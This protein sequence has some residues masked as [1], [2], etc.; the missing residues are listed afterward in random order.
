MCAQAPPGTLPWPWGSYA[1]TIYTH[2]WMSLSLGLTCEACSESATVCSR[3]GR[4]TVYGAQGSV[5]GLAVDECPMWYEMEQDFTA[6]IARWVVTGN[7]TSV[8]CEAALS[9]FFCGQQRVFADETKTSISACSSHGRPFM[10][11]VHQCLSFCPAILDSC[12]QAEAAAW[13]E[14]KCRA[15]FIPSY[16]DILDLSGVSP[17]L[18]PPDLVDINNL[19]RLESEAGLPLLRN[20]RPSYRSIPAR[21]IG[22]GGRKNKLDY[23]LYSTNER[24]YTE[25]LIDPNDLSHDGA[26]AFVASAEMHPRVVNSEWMVWSPGRREWSGVPLRIVCRADVNSLSAGASSARGRHAWVSPNGL[27]RGRLFGDTMGRH[28]AGWA[29]LAVPAA[30]LALVLAGRR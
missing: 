5:D 16:C 8:H 20:G 11:N 6:M 17:R 13:C 26:S 1:T 22:G 2:F 19:F 23:Y 29:A 9:A 4:T 3:P 12:P 25:W 30:S 15:T 7:R 18:F 28:G 10:A 14:E 27:A 24:G 21:R